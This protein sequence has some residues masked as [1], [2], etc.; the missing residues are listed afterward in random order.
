MATLDDA[1]TQAITYIGSLSGINLAPTDPPE[2]ADDF[3]FVVGYPGDGEWIETPAGL[4]TGL[5]N[6]IIELHVARK[7]PPFEYALT[8]WCGASCPYV[9]FAKM[10]SKWAGKI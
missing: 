2:S 1:I 4:K 10:P 6:I 3:P 7:D 9:L 8:F 5:H